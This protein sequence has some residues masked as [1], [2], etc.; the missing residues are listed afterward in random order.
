MINFYLD[1]NS[2]TTEMQQMCW[3][4]DAFTVSISSDCEYFKYPQY[5]H[6]LHHD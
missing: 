3:L 6:M 2:K 1:N 5:E 4:L